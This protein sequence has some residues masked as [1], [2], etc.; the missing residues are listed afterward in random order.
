MRRRHLA[1]DHMKAAMVEVVAKRSKSDFRCIPL[2]AEHWF[3]EEHTANRDAIQAPDETIAAPRF[4]TVCGAHSMQTQ[5]RSL[6]F[7]WEPS[8]FRPQGIAAASLDDFLKGSIEA[9]DHSLV[10]HWF[11]KASRGL[12]LSWKEHR[13]R[14]RTPPQDRLTMR[15]PRK[16][17]ALVRG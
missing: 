6:H 12:E 2:Q 13:A 9:R 17:S 3:T 5:V 1:V 11:S 7:G 14:I 8:A 15:V 16:D 10:A 4:H